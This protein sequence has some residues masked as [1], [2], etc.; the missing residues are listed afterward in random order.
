MLWKMSTAFSKAHPRR[1]WSIDA[2]I[3]ARMSGRYERLF[4]AVL[5]A[6]LFPE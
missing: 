3:G 6:R 2:K 1:A 5:Q 4:Q